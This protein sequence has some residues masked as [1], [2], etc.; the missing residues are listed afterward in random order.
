[1]LDWL[2]VAIVAVLCYRLGARSVRL[3]QAKARLDAQWRRDDQAYL[4]LLRTSGPGDAPDDRPLER[5][6]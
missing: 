4:D 3:R 6:D 1:M 2:L 5:P